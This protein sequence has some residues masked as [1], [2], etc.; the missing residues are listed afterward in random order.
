MAP[1]LA[2]PSTAV[3]DRLAIP[4]GTPFVLERDGSTRGTLD[5]NTYLVE[6]VTNAA[7]TPRTA[8]HSVAYHLVRF[9]T[10]LRHRHAGPITETDTHH[11]T[12]PPLITLTDTIAPDLLAYREHRQATISARTWNT[13][14]SSLSAFFTWAVRTG[15]MDN[16]PNP[17]WGTRQR[18]TLIAREHLEFTPRYL[19]EPQLR[20]FL[21]LGLRR[22]HGDHHPF[23]ERD[24]AFGL[25]LVS[26]GLRREE[27][28]LLLDDE[29]PDTAQLQDADVV[30]FTRYGKGNRPRRVYLTA[31][32]VHAIDL[33]RTTTRRHLIDTHQPR[34]RRA[35]RRGD[36][37]EY[38]PIGSADRRPTHYLLDGAR[39]PI[40]RL[41]NEQR[42]HAV[43]RRPDGTLEPLGL[44][45]G[46]RA[47]PLNPSSWNRI[48]ADA[49]QH[50]RST[51]H[52]DRPPPHIRVTP[53]T[54]RHTFAVRMLAALMR[55]GR[56][57]ASNPYH[58]LASPTITVQQLM[59]HASSETTVRY[60]LSAAANYDEELPAALRTLLAHAAGELR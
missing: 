25:A 38:R 44:F 54:L 56:E 34:L 47:Q 32:L 52:P 58:L 43:Q 36:L 31:G 42:R 18:N 22:D 8:S 10:F 14:L 23:A 39:I 28:A 6:A 37:H 45:L 48:F 33:Y 15:R 24:Y 21:H 2:R 7:M 59:G 3:L 27:G 26:T 51:D 41:T 4:D 49:D 13:E 30:D 12:A 11:R 19:T 46:A 50:L 5:L 29:F 1:E 16:D 35:L 60:Y 40:A 57:R 55:L 9:L 17:R 53:H 20:A